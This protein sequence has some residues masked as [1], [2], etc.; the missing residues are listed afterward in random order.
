MHFFDIFF[1]W[2]GWV[3]LLILT[4]L[5]VVLGIDNIIFI[6]IITDV[7]P[8]NKKRKARNIGLGL[9]LVIRLILLAAVVWLMQLTKPLF[10][11]FDQHFSVQSIILLIGGLFLIYKGDTG[12]N[13]ISIIY[14]S[15]IISMVIMMAFAGKISNF[16]SENP[17]I[18]MIALSFL[19][20]VGVLLVGEAFGAHIPKGYVYFGLVFSLI[21]ELM[22]IKMRKNSA[23]K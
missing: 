16:I 20:T 12:K 4:V 9:A 2:Q 3:Y 17:T 7:L 14:I 10:P 5:E 22:N 23:V 13:P 19:V 15:V 8:V 11:Q 21:V 1:I 6:S 18:K